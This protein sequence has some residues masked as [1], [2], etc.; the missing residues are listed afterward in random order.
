[1]TE[2]AFK[3]LL[4]DNAILKLPLQ[5]IGGLVID[6]YRYQ[7]CIERG[8][9]PEIEEITPTDEM[10]CVIRIHYPADYHGT[11]KGLLACVAV[12]FWEEI[13]EEVAANRGDRIKQGLQLKVAGGE[14]LKHR[15]SRAEA[16]ALVGVSGRLVGKALELKGNAPKLFDRV[17]QH[18]LKFSEAYNEYKR[19][20]SPKDDIADDFNRLQ[21]RIQKLSKDCEES[22]PETATAAKDLETSLMQEYKAR[23]GRKGVGKHEQAKRKESPTKANAHP[24][25]G[26][27]RF[28][29]AKEP[30]QET[31]DGSQPETGNRKDSEPSASW[32]NEPN[33]VAV[34]SQPEHSNEE[35]GIGTANKADEDAVGEVCPEPDA[36]SSD[37]VSQKTQPAGLTDKVPTDN[38]IVAA[39]NQGESVDST[40]RANANSDDQE[41]DSGSPGSD[42]DKVGDAGDAEDTNRQADSDAPGDA[43]GESNQIPV[44]AVAQGGHQA[45]A[46]S[47]ASS[48]IKTP[49]CVAPESRGAPRRVQTPPKSVGGESAAPGNFSPQDSLFFELM[50]EVEEG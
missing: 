5:A 11:D 32:Q 17:Y 36:D 29:D 37:Q 43:I 14:S 16:G 45:T 8:I 25:K 46:K 38:S 7:A 33:G 47:D 19:Q 27:G 1:M 10:D 4:H 6:R 34:A 26:E 9:E 40:H 23:R 30:L 13:S 12:Q 41:A 42:G 48:G 3:R 22:Y 21:K 35:E 18:E 44:P 28:S 50:H 39:G 49:L 24:N 31:P 20:G 15:D 2:E